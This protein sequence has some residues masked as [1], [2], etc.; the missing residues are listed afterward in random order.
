MPPSAPQAR[1]R[2]ASL[3]GSGLPA[4]RLQA[5][6]GRLGLPPGR[7]GAAPGAAGV[8][9]PEAPALLVFAVPPEIRD[10]ACWAPPVAAWI[11]AGDL[12]D[13]ALADLAGRAAAADLFV[14][15]TTATANTLQVAR[16]VVQALAARR[17]LT[18]E[19]GG[20]IEFALHEA[21]SN[22]V[23]HGNL[24]VQGMKG[25]TVAAL[26][27]FSQDLADRLAEPAL[28]RR[29]VEI[30]LRIAGETLWIDVADEG[31]G[32]LPAAPD[33]PAPPGRVAGCES[34]GRGLDLIGSVARSLRLLDGGRRI[35]MEFAL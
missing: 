22:A 2:F 31:E 4:G 30:G 16:L 34:S 12:E 19:R 1:S 27:R 32:F 20:D 9:E 11:E 21:V 18:E 6:A 26:E 23:V 15:V 25:L 17:A 3:R 5:L 35:R 13:A 24:Q 10:P 7:D 14:S 33:A 8:G 29:R 28:A